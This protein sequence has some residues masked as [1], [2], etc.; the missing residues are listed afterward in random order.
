ML[1]SKASTTTGSTTTLCNNVS[2]SHCHHPNHFRLRIIQINDVY[3][4]D[5]LPKLKSLIDAYKHCGNSSNQSTGSQCNDNNSSTGE[6]SSSSSSNGSS[7]TAIKTS[8]ATAADLTIVIC[9][10]DFAA[11]SLLSSLDEGYGMIDVMNMCG[12]D[13]VCFGNHET[14]ISISAL[15]DRIVHQSHFTWINSNMIPKSCDDNENTNNNHTNGD[16]GDRNE[17][18]TLP[19]NHLPEYCEIVV[20]FDENESHDNSHLSGDNKKNDDEDNGTKKNDA[21]ETPRP[22]QQ[23]QRIVLLGLLTDDQSL[24]RPNNTFGGNVTILPILE[25]SKGLIQQL[26]STRMSDSNTSHNDDDKYDQMQLPPPPTPPFIIPMTHQSIQHDRVLA[27]AIGHVC[28]IICGGHDHEIYHE[29]VPTNNMN[30]TN[31]KCNE[32]IVNLNNNYDTCQIVKAGMDAQNAAIIDIVWKM[33]DDSIDGTTTGAAQN[34]VSN[35]NNNGATITTKP[36]IHVQIVSSL[37]YEP[38]PM[39]QQRVQQH[40]KKLQELEQASLFRISDWATAIKASNEITSDAGINNTTDDSTTGNSTADLLPLLFSTMNNRIQPS[41]GTTAICTMLQMGMRTNLCIINAG[42]IRGNNIYPL[43]TTDNIDT[44]FTWANLKNEIPFRTDMCVCTLPGRI[45]DEMIQHSRLGSY[46]HLSAP[47]ASGGYLHTCRNVKY[48]EEDV[49]VMT[50]DSITTCIRRLRILSIGNEPFDPNRGYLTAFPKQFFDGIDNHVPLL[51]W[52]KTTD[53]SSISDET[54]IP[55]K[56][57]LVQVFAATMWLQ[58]GQFDDIDENQDGMISRDEIRKRLIQLNNGHCESIADLIVDNLLSVC[59]LNEDGMIS[60]VEMMIC[61]YVATDMLHHVGTRDEIRTITKIVMDVLGTKQHPVLGVQ[62][63]KDVGMLTGGDIS[64][65]VERIR[66]MI[67]VRGDGKINR[68]D[69][70]KIFKGTIQRG[71]DLLL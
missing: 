38:D 47:I 33:Y 14:D 13:Y 53:L 3:E 15:Y 19:W 41:T 24:Y 63:N 61:Q 8:V 9:C 10:G 60:P 71:N 31:I 58:M 21:H 32:R 65:L 29:F 40:Q 69:I 22:L 66:Q 50:N 39:V 70:A 45:I 1:K 37:S 68:S 34:D 59:D 49:A 6:L 30:I 7:G 51:E 67:D 26:H 54:C 11:P 43:T 20:N 12:I 44:Y 64:R 2:I 48:Q 55:A 27:Q 5:H 16:G 23:Q 18:M 52:A 25:R 28:P 36:I 57:V 46:Q 62:K 56:M 42:A 17:K 4:L 35:P